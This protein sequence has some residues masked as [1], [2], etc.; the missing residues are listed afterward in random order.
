MLYSIL[1]PNTPY[2]IITLEHAVVTGG[3]FLSTHTL[4]DSLMGHIHSFLLPSLLTEGKNPPLTIFARRLVHYMHNA[5]VVNDSSD[6]SHLL[7]L[8]SMDDARDFFSLIAIAIFLNVLDE[9]T[10]QLSSDTFQEDPTICEQRHETF[11]LNAIPVAE[12]HHLCYTRGLAFDLLKWLFEHY[13]FSSE[14]LEE[15][16]VDS[17][18]AIFVPFV[19]HVGRQIIRYKGAAEARGHATSSTSTQV[20]RQ[21]QSALFGFRFMKDSWFEEEAAEEENDD[22]EDENDGLLDPERNDLY[23]SF[24]DFAFTRRE[25]PETRTTSNHDFLEVGKTIRDGLFFRGLD[26]QFDL[27]AGKVYFF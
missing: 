24:D 4:H 27:E 5:Y 7:S 12:R 15:P 18:Q 6:R 8:S 25:I 2:V 21:V 19:V 23:F 17:Y 20:I 26:S 3:F 22:Y 10:Y 16:D 1:R 11:D 14:N 9:R 13:S